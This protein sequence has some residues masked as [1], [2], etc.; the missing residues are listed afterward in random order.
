MHT[1]SFFFLAPHLSLYLSLPLSTDAAEHY[2]RVMLRIGDLTT[3]NAAQLVRLFLSPHTST[4]PPSHSS[5]DQQTDGHTQKPSPSPSPSSDC[6]LNFSQVL[7]PFAPTSSSSSSSPSVS[8]S[9]SSPPSLSVLPSSLLYTHNNAIASA[10]SVLHTRLLSATLSDER[11]R[12]GVVDT[13]RQT[14]NSTLSC[15]CLLA[16][17]VLRWAG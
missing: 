2:V 13:L 11:V 3:E 8:G 10:L 12:E 1:H 17:M 16:A 14:A 9:L 7:W 6:T 5:G 15:G 4:P